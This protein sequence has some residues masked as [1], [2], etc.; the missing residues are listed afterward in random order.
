MYDL[1]FIH[2][3]YVSNSRII[4]LLLKCQSGL[5]RSTL[6]V[7]N[8]CEEIEAGHREIVLQIVASFVSS[9]IKEKKVFFEAEL[10]F[11]KSLDS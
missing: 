9:I 2:E 3:Q 11:E 7:I 6:S 8:L 5:F 1:S 4:H 10:H